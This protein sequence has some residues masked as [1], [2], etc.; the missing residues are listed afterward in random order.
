MNNCFETSPPLQTLKKSIRY[1][2]RWRMCSKQIPQNL[3]Q[4]VPHFENTKQA[5]DNATLKRAYSLKRNFYCG[6]ESQNKR[7]KKITKA[8]LPQ[9][10]IGNWGLFCKSIFVHV[11]VKIIHT[12]SSNSWFSF[13]PKKTEADMRAL[14]P[15]GARTIGKEKSGGRSGTILRKVGALAV[16]NQPNIDFNKLHVEGERGF[17]F[18][19]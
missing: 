17:I 10:H 18:T 3:L 12:E 8:I 9:H 13:P 14:L 11:C 19:G 5:P 6:R 2:P 1:F 15:L 7:K 16:F 4:C